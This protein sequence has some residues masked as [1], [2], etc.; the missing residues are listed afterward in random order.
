MPLEIYG[1]E[2]DTDFGVPELTP[3]RRTCQNYPE[4]ALTIYG[5]ARDAFFAPR[6][7]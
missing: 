3:G 7:Q 4:R 6:L 2:Q 1:Q 5:H